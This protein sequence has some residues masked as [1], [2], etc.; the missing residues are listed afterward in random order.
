MNKTI[1]ALLILVSGCAAKPPAQLKTETVDNFDAKQ[2]QLIEA[3]RSPTSVTTEFPAF[4]RGYK[5]YTNEE[6]AAAM[7][8]DGVKSLT[9]RDLKPFTVTAR[10]GNIELKSA[11]TYSSGANAHLQR[12]DLFVNGALLCNFRPKARG[13]AGTPSSEEMSSCEGTM[14]VELYETCCARDKACTSLIE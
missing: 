9:C 11:L 5:S 1:L 2:Q 4:I 7:S 14:K 12:M 3:S 6:L 13:L 8:A 10:Q